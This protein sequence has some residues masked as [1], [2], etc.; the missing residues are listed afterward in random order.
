MIGHHRRIALALVG[1]VLAGCFAAP[2]TSVEPS[3]SAAPT[4]EPTV[5]VTPDPTIGA[6]LPAATEIA[7]G[8]PLPPYT[9]ECL[10]IDEVN[11][12]DIE[13]LLGSVDADGNGGDG[14]ISVGHVAPRLEVTRIQEVTGQRRSITPPPLEQDNERGQLLGGHEF[15]TYPSLWFDGHVNPQAMISAS[16]TLTLEGQ[17]PIALPTRFVPGN[18]NFDQVAATVPDASGPGALTLAFVWADPCFRYEASATIAVDVVPVS[19]TA[20]CALERSTYF[21]QVVALLDGSINVGSTTVRAFSPRNDAKFL[22]WG[23]FGIDAFLVYA[24]DPSDPAIVA[25]PGSALTLAQASSD[26][27]IGNDM[28][29]TVWTRASVAKAI[30]DYP[31]FGTVVVLSRTPV[32]QADGTFRL[33]VPQDPGRYVAGVELTYDSRCSSG[34]LWVIVNIDVVAPVATPAPSASAAPVG[35]PRP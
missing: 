25:A 8:S 28:T 23:S 12:A 16:V 7:T 24:F 21:D 30:K 5:A 33:R 35:A 32:K 27:T 34:T 10:G 11:L 17:A 22:P 26:I 20:G 31:P 3:T 15:V 18:V 29:L 13:A 9:G 19:V 1:F 6:S 4:V 14:G 2:G